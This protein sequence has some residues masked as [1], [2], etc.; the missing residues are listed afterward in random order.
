MTKRSYRNQVAMV[1]QGIASAIKQAESLLRGAQRLFESGDHAL[2]LS[3]A[4]LSLEEIGK[5][6]LIDGLLLAKAKDQKSVAF[7]KG[8]RQHAEKLR[9][10]EFLPMFVEKHAVAD[11][12]FVA[13][14]LNFK[15]AIASELNKFIVARKALQPFLGE[16]LLVALDGLKQ[17]GFYTELK[18]GNTFILPAQAINPE[19]AAAVISLASEALSALRILFA[20]GTSAFETFVSKIRSAMTESDHQAFEAAFENLYAG[21]ANTAST[22]H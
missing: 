2:A 13:S 1:F 10:V 22:K 8:H 14:S 6:F 4:V 18:D 21:A 7:E 3:V 19:L 16:Q 9:A 12:R 15:R 17:R 20:N 5:A 11:P